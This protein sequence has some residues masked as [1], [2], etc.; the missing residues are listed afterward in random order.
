MTTPGEGRDV[1]RGPIRPTKFDWEPMRLTHLGDVGDVVRT[2]GGKLSPVGG[3]PG[4]ARK[5][6]P[7][8]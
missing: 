1:P 2:G 6:A 3:D 4:E 8:G 7:T 5:Q